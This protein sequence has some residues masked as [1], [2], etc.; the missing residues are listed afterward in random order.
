MA[1]AG[2][3]PWRSMWGLLPAEN[4]G[5]SRR[6]GNM[7]KSTRRKRA[8][9]RAAGESKPAVTRAEINPEA[10]NDWSKRI[11]AVR[12]ELEQISPGADVQLGQYKRSLIAQLEAVENEMGRALEKVA[13]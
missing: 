2:H 3:I 7:A 11:L 6:G 9:S 13:G 8:T 1:G 5:D 4:A 12:G 10:V